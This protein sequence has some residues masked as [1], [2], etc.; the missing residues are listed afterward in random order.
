MFLQANL[1]GR[2]KRFHLFLYQGRKVENI[3]LV[4]PPA[5]IINLSYERQVKIPAR[6]RLEAHGSSRQ[7]L[8]Y[9]HYVYRTEQT[10]CDWI[11]RYI[12]FFKAKHR[13]NFPGG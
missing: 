2:W 9:H 6:P 7:V 13:P 10:Y 1:V 11:L 12:R 5:D 4:F 3:P 8:R